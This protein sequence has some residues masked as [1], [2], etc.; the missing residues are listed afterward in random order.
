MLNEISLYLKGKINQFSSED[1]IILNNKIIA[2]K[3]D[4]FFLISS[5]VNPENVKTISFI[6]GGQ[7][8]ILTAANFC[9][10]LIRVGSVTFRNLDKINAEKKEFFLL[11]TA[12]YQ[13]DDLYYEARIFGDKLIDESDL[14]ICSNDQS[15]KTGLE[16]APIIKVTNMARRFAELSLAKQ[17]TADFVVLDGIL[18]P[19][20]KNEERYL[21]QLSQNIN[22]LA[23]SSSSFTT[24]GNSPV[25]L[26][27]KIGPSGCWNYKVDENTS[28]VKLHPQAKHVFR[29]EGSK[30]VLSHLIQNCG[31]ALFL[32]YP[33]GLLLADKLARVS[34]QE[35]SSLMMRFLLNK[36]N[37]D[38]ADYMT[39]S[40][41]HGILDNLG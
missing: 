11:T 17:T 32:G 30:E 24:S 29:F 35:K 16:R 14:N 6:D 8:E 2:V 21:N 1:S 40:N 3:E 19:T 31:D 7:A 37:K 22:G 18:E 23:K 38:V 5:L 20:F 33:Y 10:S 34:N 28:Y 12:K 9:L 39:T 25:V 27:N 36:E 13:E 41:A 26:L 4:N 15:I